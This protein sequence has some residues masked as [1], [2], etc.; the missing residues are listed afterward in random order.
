VLKPGG[1]FILGNG[2]AN[3]PA[4]WFPEIKVWLLRRMSPRIL[5]FAQRL[6]R[7]PPKASRSYSRYVLTIGEIR[8]RLTAAGFRVEAFY[9]YEFYVPLLIRNERFLPILFKLGE[10]YPMLARYGLF[11]ARCDSK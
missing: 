4:F 11:M 6:A 9:P 8:E 1:A 2:V 10:F 7:R 5:A 3:D